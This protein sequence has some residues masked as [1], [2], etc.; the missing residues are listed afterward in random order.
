[1]QKPSHEVEGIV[2]RAPRQDCVKTQ[3]WG[4][5]PKYRDILDENLLKT[6]D[7]SDGSPSNRTTTLSTHPRQCW[8]L[9]VLEWPSQSPALNPIKHLW[10]DLNIAVQQRSPSNL[11]ELE[12][13]CREEGEKLP[14]TG[15]PSL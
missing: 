11:T 14:N 13:I 4:R 1:M 8:S 7:W 5:V 9:N 15:V 6:S 2:R 12:R 3:I 10:R